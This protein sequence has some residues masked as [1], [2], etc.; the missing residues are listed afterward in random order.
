MFLVNKHNFYCNYWKLVSPLMQSIV[1]A[2]AQDSV[3]SRCHR[4]GTFS[5]IY[6][7]LLLG[8][9]QAQINLAHSLLMS[10]SNISSL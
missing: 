5:W 10:N 1:N 4:N 3:G 7:P 6:V 9:N 2:E 8:D